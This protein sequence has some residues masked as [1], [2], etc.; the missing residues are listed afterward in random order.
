[1]KSTNWKDI[2]ELVGISAI[3]ASLVFV[4]L[5]LRQSHEIAI[6]AEYQERAASVIEQYNAQMQSD[7]ALSVVGQPVYAAIRSADFPDEHRH[8]Y[9]GYT[10]EQLGFETLRAVNALTAFDNI[11]FQ[12]QSGFISEEAWEAF[13]HRLRRVF[14]SPITR[15]LFE[16]DSDWYRESYRQLCHEILT[17]IESEME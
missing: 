4:G 12:Y 5:E 11:Y 16:S 8:L 13:R 6:A 14:E 17:E 1:M 3:V 2:A 15:Q 10:V 9:E 7:V